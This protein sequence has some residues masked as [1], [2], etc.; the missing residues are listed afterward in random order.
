MEI[1]LHTHEVDGVLSNEAKLHVYRIIQ[2]LLNN[3]LKHANATE[4]DV[5]VNKMD[6]HLFI[7]VEDN[8]QGFDHTNAKEGLG[9]GNLKSRV[10]VLRGEMEIDSSK[11]RGTSIT[12]HIPIHTAQFEVTRS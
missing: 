10:N 2:E 4:I 9:L 8:G 5:Q 6:G 1:S 3:A 12:V 7:M 11:D